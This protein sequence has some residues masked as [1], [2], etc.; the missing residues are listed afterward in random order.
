MLVAF[1]V[2]HFVINITACIYAWLDFVNNIY[3]FS[4]CS[5]FYAE[6]KDEIK[7]QTA[8]KSEYKDR[9]VYFVIYKS[10]SSVPFAVFSSFIV[11][12]LTYRSIINLMDYMLRNIG[13]ATLQAK[14]TKQSKDS[15]CCNFLN[16]NDEHEMI[17]SK[18][19][20]DYVIDLLSGQSELVA[21][22]SFKKLK[23]YTFSV[24]KVERKDFRAK[25]E[26]I[27]RKVLSWDNNFRFTSRYMNTLVVS[28]VVLYYFVLWIT[29]TLAYW[30][31]YLTTYLPDDLDFTNS[32]I[33]VGD[34]FCSISDDF[35]IEELANFTQK[36][37][38][39]DKIIQVL[40][41]LRTSIIW[42]FAA[43]LI[44]SPLIC[45]LQVFLFS[46]DLKTHL[47]QLY[48]GDCDFVRSAEAIGNASIATASFHFGGYVTGYLVWGYLIIY[49]AIVALGLVILGIRIFLPPKFWLNLLLRIV[50]VITALIIKQIINKVA[51]QIIF[52][53]RNS[54][55][56]AVNN[57]RAFNVFL[58]FNFFFDCFMGVV[59]AVI[60]LVKAVLL[61]IFMLPRKTY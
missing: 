21:K 52:L 38:V 17:Y 39:P 6:I 32:E 28:L 59:S 3:Q 35:C 22:K 57:F 5:G 36:L 26:N 55:I 50:P 53:N 49:V 29:Y 56:L 41:W 11:I 9:Y 31:V 43:P 40:P 23:K 27:L 60:R 7:S 46:R 42:V 30:S 34:I 10:F 14:L 19:D 12:S 20:I 47:K 15:F 16:V 8:D 25:V 18:C 2:D 4:V 1:R 13:N 48:K 61:A 51:S 54:K 44:I 58:Y 45:L 24:A 37:P 33:S